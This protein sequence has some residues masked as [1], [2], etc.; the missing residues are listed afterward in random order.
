MEE[1]PSGAFPAHLRFTYDAYTI[2]VI[3][4]CPSNLRFTHDAYTIVVIDGMSL[5][6]PAHLHFTYDAYTIAV[7]E[8]IFLMRVTV[9][10]RFTHDA[11]TI[12]VIK[13]IFLMRVYR[14]FTLYI[15]C[16]YYCGIGGL[17]LGRS[18]RVEIFRQKLLYFN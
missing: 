14:P 6:F 13:G 7:I 17:L 8:G 3:D 15:R 10:L 9:H 5:G 1:C 2:A 11:Y 18:R 4:A 16:L 12:A